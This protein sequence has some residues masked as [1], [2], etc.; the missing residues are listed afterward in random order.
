MKPN[1][2]PSPVIDEV[3]AEVHR[4]KEA[5]AAAHNYDIDSLLRSLRERQQGNPRLVT[6]TTKGEQGGGGKG[7]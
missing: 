7:G 6:L 2:E 4:H 1:D 5:I 3:I